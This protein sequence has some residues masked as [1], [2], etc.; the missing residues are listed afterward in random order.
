MSEEKND[1]MELDDERLEAVSGGI[2]VPDKICDPYV[3]F[4]CEGHF[5]G[6]P[7]GHPVVI[8]F[9]YGD[10]HTVFREKKCFTC[11]KK[12]RACFDMKLVEPPVDGPKK[13]EY[14]E[15]RRVTITT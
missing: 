5:R 6:E 4:N 10:N 3:R 8:Y 12:Y 7:C 15:V 2:K 14:Q 11:G 13:W 1:N 9:K